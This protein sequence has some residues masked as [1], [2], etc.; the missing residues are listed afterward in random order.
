MTTSIAENNYFD[1]FDFDNAPVV[2]H[3]MITKLQ[4]AKQTRDKLSY[5]LIGRLDMDVV[6]LLAQH[7]HSQKDIERINTMVRLL[8]A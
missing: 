8:F 1:D 4:T 5:E 2:K 3:S 6:E 7:A